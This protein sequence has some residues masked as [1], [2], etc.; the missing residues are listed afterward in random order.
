MMKKNNQNE[1]SEGEILMTA[2]DID[3][4]S[5]DIS[6]DDIQICYFVEDRLYS[7]LL[8]DE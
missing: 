8:E 6:P 3:L 2:D 4:V 7:G 5:D 1:S